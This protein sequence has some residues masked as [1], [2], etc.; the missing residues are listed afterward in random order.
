MSSVVKAAQ[1]GPVVME[2]RGENELTAVVAVS[3]LMWDSQRKAQL[4]FKLHRN[5]LKHS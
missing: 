5:N 1:D 2:T 4:L 3:E